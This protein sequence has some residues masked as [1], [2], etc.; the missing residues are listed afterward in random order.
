MAE[1]SLEAGAVVRPEVVAAPVR[2]DFAA[3][4]S[5]L[6]ASITHGAP[7]QAKPQAKRARTA[8]RPDAGTSSSDRDGAA[9]G[10]LSAEGDEAAASSAFAAASSPR[11]ASSSSGGAVVSATG[12]VASAQVGH[13]VDVRQGRCL[14]LLPRRLHLARFG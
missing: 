14:R 9:M 12:A 10:P 1:E 13:H 6:S 8:S 3:D 2:A 4:A 11:A 7:A 5:E